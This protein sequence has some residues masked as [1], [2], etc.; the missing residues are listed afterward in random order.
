[1]RREDFRASATGR[2]VPTISGQS[3]FVPDTLP[4]ALDLH[5]LA[6]PLADAVEAVGELNGIGR[7]LE[8]PYL[9]IRP[10]QTKEA[11]TSSSMEGTYST[12]DELML[13][14]AGS[15]GTGSG[16]T[17]EVRNYGRALAQ[18]IASLNTL[19]LC[20]R[21]ICDAHAT[22][23]GGLPPARGHRGRPGELKDQQNWIGARTIEQA[24]FIPPP[25]AESRE[26]LFA[27]EGYIQRDDRKSLHPL[28]DAALIHYQFE[29]IHP[30]ADGNGRVG[31]IIVPVLLLERGL[32]H[33]PLLYLSPF[34]ERRKDDYI[35]LMFEV[36]RSGDWTSWIRFFLGAVGSSARQTIEVADRLFVLRR[37][38][39]AA[40]QTARRP[41][42]LLRLID[43]LFE[44]PIFSIPQVEAALDISYP[45]AQKNIETLVSAG[46]VEEVIG[47]AYPKFF[48]ARDIIR[49]IED[50][51]RSVEPGERS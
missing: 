50:I 34:L 46:I 22:L 51:G 18:T 8:N 29:T 4:P 31:R 19:P 12:I 33:Q 35:D 6:M 30:F 3:A 38:Y 37:D 26:A 43:R 21:T 28:I 24:R 27:L 1:M 2:L 11:L 15:E 40:F 48:A 42:L 16:D 13:L 47:T 20:L 10:L 25:P 44:R 23:L 14:E 32:L 41:A 49:A 45:S 36:S 5:A 7:T 9:L 17:R 39:R